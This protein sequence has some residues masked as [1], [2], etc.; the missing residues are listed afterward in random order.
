MAKTKSSTTKKTAAKPAAKKT[1]AKSAPAAAKTTTAKAA[2]KAAP[3]KAAAKKAPAVKITDKQR[4][5]LQKIASAG[6]GGYSSDSKPELRSIE[7]LQTKKL[8]KKG[9]KDKASGKVPYSVT[10]AGEKALSAPAPGAA[11]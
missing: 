6:Q 7:A 4:E 8:V 5:L 9:A 10:K 2:T 11:G 3:K 1:T